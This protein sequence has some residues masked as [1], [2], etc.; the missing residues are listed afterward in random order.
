MTGLLLIWCTVTV[1]RDSA[2]FITAGDA[3]WSI[4]RQARSLVP[5]LPPGA[6]LYFTG[7]PD[8]VTFRWGLTQ[9]IRYVFSDSNLPVYLVRDGPPEWDQISL[10]TV[11]CK[12][13]VPQFYFRYSVETEIVSLIDSHA[14]GLSCP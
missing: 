1:Y 9:E 3:N 4:P 2:Y 14:F 8:D 13:G 11:Q 7:I 12:S 5:N 6:E 10:S